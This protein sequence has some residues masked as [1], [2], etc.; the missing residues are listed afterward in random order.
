MIKNFRKLTLLSLVTLFLLIIPSTQSSFLSPSPLD[1]K[2]TS[3]NPVIAVGPLI[4]KVT[5][6]SIIVNWEMDIDTMVNTVHWGVTKDCNNIAEESPTSISD[7]KYLHSVRI[8]G[9]S[10]STKYYYKVVSDGCVSNVYSFHTAYDI[11]GIIS[12]VAYGDTRGVWD[13]WRNASMVAE[14][15]KKQAPHFAIHTGDLVHNG[16]ID[17]E[18]IDFFSISDFTHNST[19]YPCLGNHESYGESYFEYFSLPNNEYWY[20]FDTGPVHFI[21]LDSNP[22]N[23]F[24]IK[25]VFWLI[26]DLVF[27]KQPFKIVFFHHPLYSSGSHGSGEELRAIYAPIF[28][29]FNVDIV[30][31]GHDHHYER[32]VVD[33]ITYVV[34]GGGGAPIRNVGSSWWTIYSESTYHYCLLTADESRLSFQALK[35]DGT[36]LDSFIISK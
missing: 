13:N 35:P 9:L 8:E 31:N 25:Q 4:Q 2:N 32:G 3:Q 18:W 26:I 10:H 34:T 29:F 33:D 14:A 27:N 24:K 20:S 15:I 7:D 11:D 23:A 5:Q 12:F 22:Y 19:L 28:N 16:D 1:F 30:F 36:I 21:C 17:S 6:N